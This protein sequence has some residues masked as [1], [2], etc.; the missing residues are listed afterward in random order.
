MRRTTSLDIRPTDDGGVTLHGR[1]RDLLTDA[2]S[3][4]RVLDT[5]LLRLGVDEQVRVRSASA[6]PGD[7][8]PLVGRPA[9]LGFRTAVW[10]SLREH[11]DAG[12]ALHQL[13]DDV[14]GAMVISG[15][16][17]RARLGIGAAHKGPPRRPID[18][19]VGWAADSDAVR[20]LAATGRAAPLWKPPAPDLTGADPAGAHTL[21]PLGPAEVRRARRIDV[22]AADDGAGLVAD[23]G[24]R[25]TLIEGDGVERVLH[26]YQMHVAVDAHG[27]VTE[28]IATAHVLPHLECPAA[29]RSTLRVVGMPVERLRESVSA[30]FFGPSTCTHL[31]DVLRGLT[32]LPA[33][34]AAL[35]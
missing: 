32:D 28:C 17:A 10:R 33:L 35:A 16:S 9:L 24:H 19:C 3:E 11:Y 2:S 27:V 8:T 12:T 25:D 1:G 29:T 21:T 13:L 15:L 31:N 6:H 14:P 30:E 22:R 7:V 20:R 34:A 4:H 18:V 23:V 5:A 26:E